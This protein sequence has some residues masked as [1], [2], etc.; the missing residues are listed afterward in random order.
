MRSV[1]QLN[2]IHTMRVVTVWQQIYKE[3]RGHI[4]LYKGLVSLLT[5]EADVASYLLYQ[6]N[7]AER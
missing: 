2:A 4:N 5:D 1:R 3:I 6:V 7:V